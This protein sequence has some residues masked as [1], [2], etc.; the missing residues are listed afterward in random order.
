TVSITLESA[1]LVITSSTEGLPLYQ[2]KERLLRTPGSIDA[3]AESFTTVPLDMRTTSGSYSVAARSWS[4]V[5]MVTARP[6]PSNTPS[7][8]AALVLA[9]EVRTSSIDNPIE[10]SAIGL[11]R[12]RIAGCSAPLTLTSATPSICD[13]RCATTLSAAS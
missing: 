2:P 3:T 9:I 13:R 8:P 6:S 7:G 11:T 5:L 12:T 1:D 10:A 4:L